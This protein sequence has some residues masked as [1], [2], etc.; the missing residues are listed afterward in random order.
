[1]SATRTA[2]RTATKPATARRPD[3]MPIFVWEG[4]DKRGVKMT[5]EQPAKN[6][7]LVRADLRRQGITPQVVKVKQG[8]LSLAEINRVTK[9]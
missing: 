3:A 5:G 6:V 7:N 1:M 4:T 8:V 9:D 2:T